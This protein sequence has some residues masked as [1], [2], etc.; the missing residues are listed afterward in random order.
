MTEDFAQNFNQNTRVTT[1]RYRWSDPN[2]NNDYDAG[3]VN[4]SPTSPDS[5]A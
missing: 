5:S 1:Y 4:L 2:G 3:E